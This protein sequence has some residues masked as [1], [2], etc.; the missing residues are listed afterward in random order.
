M[1]E[2]L[3][4]VTV[5]LRTNGVSAHDRTKVPETIYEDVKQVCDTDSV[6]PEN[7]KDD[8]SHSLHH[9]VAAG[10]GVTCLVLVSVIVALGVRFNAA[11]SEQDSL[12]ARNLQLRK[13]KADLERR[14]EELTRGKDRLNWTIGAI[15]EYENFP[16]QTR[17]PEKV[18]KACLDD[19]VPFQSKCYQFFDSQYS[20]NWKTWRESQKQCREANANL[21]K[22]ESQEEQEFISNHTKYYNDEM[23]GYW[24]GLK[25]KP[26][27]G[28]WVDGSNV[29][30][31]YW[32]TESSRSRRSCVLTLS[33][34][35]PLANWA[36]E[37][38]TMKNRWI[39]E[40]KALIRN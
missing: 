37:Y 35:D 27:P 31:T 28:L 5:A 30:L 39:C 15:L 1:E 34:A 25:E 20:S 7:K 26:N 24:I 36:T 4:Y 19:W 9:R 11:M 32:R 17:C 14:T 6:Q 29:T 22:I 38:C 12:T 40:G 10:L 13:E 18:C 2:E 33:R 8:P 16:V 3:N 23:H 21:V